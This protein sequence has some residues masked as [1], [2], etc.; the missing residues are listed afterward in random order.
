MLTLVVLV[1]VL[2]TVAL[3]TGI[4]D[5]LPSI[6]LCFAGIASVIYAY[7]HH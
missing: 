4:D 3:I 2:I 6:L 5:N 1:V 7:V